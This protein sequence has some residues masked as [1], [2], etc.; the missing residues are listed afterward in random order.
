MHRAFVLSAVLLAAC[1]LSACGGPYVIQGKVIEADMTSIWF[2]QPSDDD[3][4]QPG[5]ANATVSIYRDGGRPNQRLIAT[6]RSNQ[7][8][9][10]TVPLEG[11]DS[12]GAGWMVEQWLV[13]VTRPGYQT[14]EAILEFPDRKSGES[15][16]VLLSPGYSPPSQQSESLWDEYER[17]K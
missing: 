4:D 9:E 12:F 7:Q 2:V 16:L 13:Q 8:G 5:V 14:V 15:L 3:L 1:M 6:G 17:F 11:M 10:F